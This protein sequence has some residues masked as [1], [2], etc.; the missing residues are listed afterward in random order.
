M[1]GGARLCETRMLRQGW[2]FTLLPEEQHNR[3][4]RLWLPLND[5]AGCGPLTLCQNGV[6]SPSVMIPKAALQAVSQRK[7]PTRTKSRRSSVLA[8]SSTSVMDVAEALLWR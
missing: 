7:Q 4:L 6:I 8:D 1:H 5:V 2:E 3:R